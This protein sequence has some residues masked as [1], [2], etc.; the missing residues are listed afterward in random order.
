[1]RPLANYG[2]EL[3]TV[4]DSY[5]ISAA[6]STHLGARIF[7]LKRKKAMVKVR[8][9]CLGL[10]HDALHA[11]AASYPSIVWLLQTH[12]EIWTV[13][14]KMS[15]VAEPASPIEDLPIIVVVI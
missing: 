12:L 7:G 8:A 3:S 10:S 4:Y 15:D 11:R 1:M 6:C 14:K 9:Q 13:K 2:L 5:S